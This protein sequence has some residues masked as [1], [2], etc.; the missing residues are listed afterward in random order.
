VHIQNT[1]QFIYEL[2]KANKPY[3]LQLDPKS[4]HGVVD[5]ALNAHMRAAMWKFI[6][7][8]LAVK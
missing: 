8:N 2:E 5:P 4:R 1:I 6:Q 7:E 3:Q